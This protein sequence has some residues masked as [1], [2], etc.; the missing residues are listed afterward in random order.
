MFYEAF[1]VRVN[2]CVQLL[3]ELPSILVTFLVSLKSPS[4]ETQNGRL[5][6][7]YGTLSYDLASRSPTN[8]ES[9][10]TKQHIV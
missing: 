2:L 1:L 7:V 10:H 4:S 8:Y 5:D 9:H 3:R 6:T